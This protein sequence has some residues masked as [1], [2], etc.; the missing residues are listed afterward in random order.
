[1]FSEDLNILGFDDLQKRCLNKVTWLI[2]IY[3][4]NKLKITII[5]IT[6]QLFIF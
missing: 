4:P 6:I 5:K 2:K 3:P 1:M